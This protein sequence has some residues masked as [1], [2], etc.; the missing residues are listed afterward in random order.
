[1]VAKHSTY[2]SCRVCGSQ[3]AK[4]LGRCPDCG[5]WNTLIEEKADTTVPKNGRRHPGLAQSTEP[6]S[7]AKI[8]R[9]QEIRFSSG[10]S[11]FD[12]VLGGGIVPGSVVLVGG[13]PGIGKSTLLLQAFGNLARKGR[14]VLYITGEES[15]DQISMRGSRLG[16]LEDKLLVL[17]ETCLEEI[18]P[19]I[20]KKHSPAVVID[21]IQTIYT[22]QIGSAPGCVSQ[23]REVSSN[24]LRYAK[25][26]DVAIFLIGH[27][28]KDGAI[29]GPRVLEHMVDTVLYFEGDR[30]HQYRILR[31]HKNRFGST[32]EIGIFEMRKEGLREVSNP[33]ELFLADR[34]C[35]VSGS[36]V[37]SCMEGTRP[38]LV[39]LQA[40]VTSSN[41]PG[42]PRRMG[43]GLDH[44]RLSMLIAILEKRMGLQLR[45]QDIFVNVA[46]GLK[47]NEP[48]V[49]L[50]I[51][52]TVASSFLNKAIDI[53]T[54]IMGE[55]GLGGKIRPISQID[56]RVMEAVKLGFARCIL[57]RTKNMEIAGGE[58]IRLIKLD[59][60][61]EAF[62][63][64]F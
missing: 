3:S 56:A 5:E 28:T 7:I 6:T 19:W 62:D 24:L 34:G 29:A 38:I 47:L 64:L 36:T 49:D 1:M 14:E 41:N 21:S 61:T 59:T 39:E 58:K 27:V 60:V 35:A 4:W 40:L 22:H 8:H 52:A 43:S 26:N 50:G 51:I 30:G 12:R 46:G 13:D 44:R 11:E 31:A 45:D 53:G 33:S 9:D 25:R 55:V 2:F 54:V 32:N 16:C 57:P 17:P 20:E 48:S 37:I 18:M 15:M 23:V 10:I 63:A 42:M